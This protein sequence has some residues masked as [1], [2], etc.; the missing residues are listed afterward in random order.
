MFEHAVQTANSGPSPPLPKRFQHPQLAMAGVQHT[1]GVHA[2]SLPDR[3]AID[4]SSRST[5]FTT[6]RLAEP[7]G[8]LVARTHPD[9]LLP[10][11]R[12][13]R[14]SAR[15]PAVS[16]V[17]GQFRRHLDGCRWNRMESPVSGK[18]THGGD[19]AMLGFIA[20]L[21]ASCAHA[22]LLRRDSPRY[23]TV[24]CAVWPPVQTAGSRQ[25]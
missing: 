17:P 12:R 2:E 14:R 10:T 20:T 19:E 13:P 8:R 3:Q 22:A 18:Q 5:L 16:S 7:A 6:H 9:Q 23:R 25:C 24:R 21:P 4:A 11:V 15:I 1:T